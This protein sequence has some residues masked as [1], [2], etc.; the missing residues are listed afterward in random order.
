M[1]P[2]GATL[3]AVVVGGGI[4]GLASAI[5]L[6]NAGHRVTVLEQARR[7]GEIGA[8]ITLAPNATSAL[9][10]L[11]VGDRLAP[12]A[13]S[14]THMVRRRWQDGALLGSVPLAEEVRRIAGSPYWHVHR[15]DLHLVLMEAAAAQGGRGEPVDLRL[16]SPVAAVEPGDPGPAVVLTEDGTRYLADLVIGA[17]GIHSVVRSSL[18]GPDSP[19]YSGDVAYRA[20]VSRGA[21]EA[22]AELRSLFGEQVLAN[23]LGPERHL[24]HYYVR[25]GSALNVLAVVPG[26]DDTRE[27]WSTPGDVRDLLATFEGW[28][29]RLLQ[30]LSLIEAT[31]RWALFDREPLDTW[32]AGRV[33]MLGDACHAMLPYQA[34]GAAQALEDAVALG[35]SLDGVDADGVE[36]A[37]KQYQEVRRP[38]ASKVQTGS[39]DNRALFHLPD[40]EE[41]RIRDAALASGGGEFATLGWLWSPV[42][43]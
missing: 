30:L 32:V 34:Q 10:L 9:Y 1:S 22:S 25:G 37:L 28:D 15:A 20:L 4:G 33:G 40:S 2:A 29:R 39:R 16:Q 24:V 12:F 6:R 18:I 26:D 21:F 38:R 36:Q 19:T 7:L 35:R 13:V 5:A 8:G 23:W 42:W 14:A 17:D 43:E 27:S 3:D 11:G 31:N 41:Q